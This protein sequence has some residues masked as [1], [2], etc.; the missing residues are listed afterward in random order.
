M[1]THFYIIYIQIYIYA[2]YKLFIA[3]IY[4]VKIIVQ[5]EQPFKEYK[6]S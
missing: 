2:S 4:L 5:H 6:K 3:S 1:H